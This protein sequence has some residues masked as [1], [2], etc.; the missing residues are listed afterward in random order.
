MNST[1]EL[2]DPEYD[3]GELGRS[4]RSCASG[5]HTNTR[6][7][8]RHSAKAPN[9]GHEA[10]KK[11]KSKPQGERPTTGRRALRGPVSMHNAQWTLIEMLLSIPDAD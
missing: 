7:N 4:L 1:E 9:W 11:T 3:G 8:R 2:E 6:N 10:E 5:C